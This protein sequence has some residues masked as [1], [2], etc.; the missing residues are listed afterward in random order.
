VGVWARAVVQGLAEKNLE[1][2]RALA[3]TEAEFRDLRG[4]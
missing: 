3:V 4:R 1:A 2:L